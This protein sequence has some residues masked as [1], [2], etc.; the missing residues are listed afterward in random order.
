MY[1]EATMSHPAMSEFEPATMSDHEF[2][3][4]LRKRKAIN[5]Y[6]QIA[7]MNCWRQGN[8]V[9]ACAIYDNATPD[10]TIYLRKGY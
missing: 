6:F 8:V 3:K 2:A 1:N 9:I 5:D 7:N 10:R 4:W